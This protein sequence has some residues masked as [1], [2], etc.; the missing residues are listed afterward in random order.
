MII[1][2]ENPAGEQSSWDL[3][4][5]GLRLVLAYEDVP[6]G[7]WDRLTVANPDELDGKWYNV[8][9]SLMNLVPN[10]T[11]SSR[12]CPREIGRGRCLSRLLVGRDQGSAAEDEI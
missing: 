5:P 3:G 11:A 4:K 8:E 10:K 9:C 7:T 2:D 1:S 12:L 6:A